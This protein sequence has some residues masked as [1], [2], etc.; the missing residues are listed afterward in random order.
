MMLGIEGVGAL[1]GCRNSNLAATRCLAKPSRRL[2]SHLKG[3][4]SACRVQYLDL[5]L[6]LGLLLFSCESCVS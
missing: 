4:S 2:K 5:Y 3:H 6:D 1:A